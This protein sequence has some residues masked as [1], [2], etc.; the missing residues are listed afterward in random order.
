VSNPTLE[1]AKSTPVARPT[2]SD[3]ASVGCAALFFLPFAAVGTFTALRAAWLAER[4][5]WREALLFALF[6][7]VFGGAGFGG[8]IGLRIA[9][10]RLKEEADRK[11]SHPD[12][13]W[14]WK[15]SWAARRIDD[16]GG[17]EMLGAW[18]FAGLWNLIS[19]PSAYFGVREAITRDKPAA[20]IV[21]LFP[22]A[23]TWLLWRAIGTTLRRRKYGVSHFELSTLPGAIGRTLDG[24]ARTT[25]QSL[26]AEGF[27]VR[28]TCLRLVTSG[29]GKSR[30]TSERILWQD[31]QRVGGMQVRDF[32]GM[33]INIPVSFR[34]PHDVEPCD[35]TDPNNRVIW[36]LT[37]SAEVPGIDYTATFE[38]PVFRTPESLRPEV[39]DVTGRSSTEP[40]TPAPYRQ[41]VGSRIQVTTN[42]RGTEIIFPAGRNPAAAGGLTGFLLIWCA[43]IGAQF[44]FHAPVIFPIVTGLFGILIAVGVLD[45]WLEV[46]KVQVGDGTVSV[47]T[48]YLHPRHERRLSR[49]E[50][51]DVVAAIGM[52]AGNTP[53]YDVEIGKKVVAGRSVRDKREA[54][55]LATTIKQALGR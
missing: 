23:G 6:G 31:E 2:L 18:I 21:L 16:S 51:S 40:A 43:A 45:L 33:G 26:P 20:Y 42:S 49:P 50:V 22:L 25:M 9:S 1:T 10:R 54:E 24:T 13:P 5:N 15:P 28:L 41:P 53:Y 36:R 34:L 19:F 27:Q 14:L 3:R 46:S 7:I 55:W 52:Q 44:Y 39:A 37:V 11:A 48:G 35:T 32:S 29:S 4:R 8:L 17:E 12:E 47:A 30:S 38:V